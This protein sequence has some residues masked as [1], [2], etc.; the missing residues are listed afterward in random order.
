MPRKRAAGGGRKPK[1]DFAG[2]SSPLSI[3]MPADLR[4]ELEAAARDSGKSVTQELLRRLN[5]SFQRD[6]DKNRDPASRALCYLLAE[7]IEIVSQ[8]TFEEPKQSEWRNNPFA[9]RVIKL[10]FNRALDALE[11]KGEMH[12]PDVN[13]LSLNMIFGDSPE[14]MAENAAMAILFLLHRPPTADKSIGQVLVPKQ[15]QQHY[16]MTNAA[17]DLQIDKE[18]KR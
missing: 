8:N 16:G 14:E 7:L 6:R 5:D 4:K 18:K 2:L 12:Q 11:P 9:F 1:G 17:R 10:A 13:W 3:R 15:E